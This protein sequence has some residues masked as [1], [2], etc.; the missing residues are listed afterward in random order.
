MPGSR[1][2][3]LKVSAT[4]TIAHR[5]DWS[6][7]PSRAL[8]VV[9]PVELNSRYRG[10]APTHGLSNFEALKLRM[11]QIE[12]AGCLVSSARVRLSELLGCGPR[13]ERR[14]ALPN[15]MR[16]IKRVVLCLRPLEQVKFHKAG[17]AVEIGFAAEP[18]L[19]EGFLGAS[20]YLEAIHGDEH[21][22]LLC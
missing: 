8:A 5:Q 15:G 2:E 9:S 1:Q 4:G 14:F 20:F 6:V 11:F 3:N 19:L 16:R 21:G 13:L 17:H 18:N 7:R 22:V 12:R 10:F